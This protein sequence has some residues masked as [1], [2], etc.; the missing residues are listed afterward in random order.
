MIAGRKLL[1]GT[2]E[3]T[4]LR[5]YVLIY[6]ILLGMSFV[7]IYP[8]LYMVSTSFMDTRDLV[9]ATV[10]WIPRR[11]SVEGFV[12]AART[13]HYFE[14]IRTSLILSLFPAVLQ[15]I[16]LAFAGYGLARFDVP[17][18]KVWIGLIIIVFLIPSA[19]TLIPRYMLFNGYGMI[20]TIWPTM[21]TALGGQGVKSSL[22]L[23]IYY[24]FF[25]TYPK[26]LDEAAMIDG[27]G[28]LSVFLRIAI[29]M[30]VPAIMVT[31]LF[32]FVWFWNETTQLPLLSGTAARTLPIQLREF[33]S[34]F[35]KYY[36]ETD[37]S[38]GGALN[39]S[40]RL[41]GTLLSIAPLLAIY[42]LLQN[43]FVQSIERT[44]IAG[45]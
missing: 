15:T 18:K 45:E 44:G 32:S 30:A 14:A 10:T 40:I 37:V 31:F 29:P 19:V 5:S 23:L 34:T 21:I 22:F 17:L 1:L 27:A 11:L 7:F 3:R 43:H 20:N 24:Q 36:P 38:A 9:D 33:S 16:T 25:C 2:Q 42:L 28:R 4:G 26:A 41:A 39:E 8:M 35:M 6:G 12:R 13:L